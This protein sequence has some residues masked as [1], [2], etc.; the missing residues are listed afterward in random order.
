MNRLFFDEFRKSKYLNLSDVSSTT[1]RGTSYT[2]YSN[3]KTFYSGQLS[4]AAKSELVAL[5][6]VEEA[7]LPKG[8]FQ[9]LAR[10]RTIY[11][12]ADAVTFT[13]GEPT[14]SDVEEFS[15][16]YKKGVTIEPEQKSVQSYVQWNANRNNIYELL[17]DKQEELSYALATKV[18]K[19]ILQDDSNG[20]L[21]ATVP[22]DDSSRGALVIYGGNNTS[23]TAISSGDGLTVTMLNEAKTRLRSRVQYYRSGGYGALEK[24]SVYKNPWKNEKTDPF[25]CII[26]PDQTRNFLDSSQFTNADQYGGRE[27]LLNGEIGKI[28]N[29]KIVESDYLPTKS[30]GDSAWDGSGNASTELTRCVLMKGRAA[31]TFVWGQEPTFEMGKVLERTKDQVV[32]WTT[33]S[34]A[35]VHDD[36]IIF[37]DVA[38]I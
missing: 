33:Y 34:G 2:G 23:D 9:Y 26:G 28:F 21:S 6:S 19:F 29:I 35:V 7:K 12:D 4:D 37:M 32:L 27:P 3:Q 20:L 5:S 13:S 30:S 22:T 36:A 15:E 25:V 24:S 18:E 1:A 10:Y 16:N 31:Y 11:P 17:R 8:H 38:T 14:G